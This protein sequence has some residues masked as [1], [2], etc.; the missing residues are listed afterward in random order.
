MLAGTP[1]S[2]SEVYRSK[3]LEKETALVGKIKRDSNSVHS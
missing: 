2:H 1:G 3:S